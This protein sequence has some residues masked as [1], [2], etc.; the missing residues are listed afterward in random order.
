MKHY[1]LSTQ[2]PDGPA[3]SSADLEQVQE[4]VDA[5]TRELEA[6]GAWVFNGHLDPASTAMVVRPRGGE[7]LM[8]DGPYAEGNEHVGGVCIIK[9]PDLDAALEWAASSP[10]RP[11]CRSRCGSSKATPTADTRSAA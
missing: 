8:T 10:G 4:D 6:A 2:Q 3:P 9:A 11:P 1:L 7:L 5:L